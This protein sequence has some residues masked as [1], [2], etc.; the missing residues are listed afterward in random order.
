MNVDMM[1]LVNT[2]VSED[3]LR[4]PEW[5][6]K[7]GLVQSGWGSS[8]VTWLNLLQEVGGA[9]VVLPGSTIARSGWGSSSVT[10]LNYCKKWVGLK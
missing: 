6:V 4:M 2:R 7:V 9:Q 8:S 10:W 3:M 5:S 1:N